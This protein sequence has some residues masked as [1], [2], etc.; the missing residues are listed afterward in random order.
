M[1]K[2]KKILSAIKEKWLI[3]I[4]RNYG[5][6]ELIDNGFILDASDDLLLVQNV[7]DFMLD[8]YSV[9][10]IGDIEKIRYSKFEKYFE[11]MLTKEGFTENIGIK[12][13]VDLT[14]LSS[15]FKTIKL[16]K[17]Y[18][19]ARCQKTNDERFI[20]GPIEEFTQKS[21]KIRYFDATGYLDEKLTGL[22]YKD[23]T[24]IEFDTEYINYFTKYL[25]KKG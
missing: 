5:D 17:T 25:R 20:I 6:N 13:K 10:K 1:K 7:S 8:G 24:T 18:V 11:M 16:N 19:I 2:S 3:K 12:Y 23:I 4:F 9:I 14:D 21:V 15:V 22:K